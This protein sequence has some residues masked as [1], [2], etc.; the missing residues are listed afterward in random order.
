MAVRAPDVAPG[1]DLHNVVPFLPRRVPD[2]QAPEVALPSDV[3]RLPA[4]ALKRERLRLAA[5]VAVSLALHGG[6][7]MAFWREPVPLASI[8][9][10]VISVEIVVGATAPPG[11][12]PTPGQQQV[13]AAAAPETETTETDKAEER[14]TA[15][16]QTVEVAREETAPEQK[17]EQQKPREAKPVEPKFEIAAAPQEPAQAEQKPAVAMVETPAPDTASAKPQETPPSPTEVTLLP[18]PEEK[19][20][21]K[22]PELKPVQAAPPK[23]V[24]DAKPAQG[25]P[26]YRRA[27][28]REGS[29]RGQG[30]DAFDRGEQ[31][32]CR[33]FRRF[34]QLPG[35]RLGA[36]APLPAISRRCPRPRR[37]GHRDG[38]VRPRR[39]RT[40]NVRAACEGLRRG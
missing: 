11:V 15:Q 37:P 7:L 40:R 9:V 35:P 8:G 2:A 5:F 4:N 33:P 10:E 21:E 30:V 25:P 13:Q 32:G 17:I 39:R 14:A 29:A 16:L 19:P 34:Q 24:K 18:Q 26:S 31:C 38:V 27:D 6:L 1:A 20:V 22:K 12:A 3:A 23:P 28:T 36:S